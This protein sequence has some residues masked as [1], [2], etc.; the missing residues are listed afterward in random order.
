MALKDT[1]QLGLNNLKAGFAL[2]VPASETLLRK[3][4]TGILVHRVSVDIARRFVIKGLLSDTSG[5]PNAKIRLTGETGDGLLH[6]L[7]AT[8]RDHRVV[9]PSVFQG[10]AER[11][12]TDF[13]YFFLGEPQDW[14]IKAQ[15]YGGEGEFLTIR[16]RGKDLLA[17]SR[18]KIFYRR[19]LFWEADRAVVVKGGYEGLAR[20]D[21]LPAGLTV[22]V[23]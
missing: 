18:R 14:Q 13:V 19:G 16:I 9:D 4:E 7:R 20:I 23:S 2:A 1:L 6:L 15:A 22:P 10:A 3:I 21:P 11:G 5:F 8:I 12:F 17:D